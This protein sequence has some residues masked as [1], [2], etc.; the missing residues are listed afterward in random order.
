MKILNFYFTIIM[1]FMFV[2]IIFILFSI[3]LSSFCFA[4]NLSESDMDELKYR[5]IIYTDVI[6]TLEGVD[7]SDYKHTF[8]VLLEK[9]ESL[10]EEQR[11]ALWLA[12]GDYRYRRGENWRRELNFNISNNEN[13]I[14]AKILFLFSSWKTQNISDHQRR[15]FFQDHIE[16]LEL[17]ELVL[18]RFLIIYK[19]IENDTLNDLAQNCPSAV[20]EGVLLPL[21]SLMVQRL[22]YCNIYLNHLCYK[23][24]LVGKSGAYFC[25]QARF[26]EKHSRMLQKIY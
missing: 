14:K 1:K 19:H 8:T 4:A 23:V 25:N 20:V 5:Q 22:P 6:A 2:K 17:K 10:S 3:F 9:Y 12:A 26:I 11:E 16:Y 15:S 7:L 18:E 24:Q 21:A 13:S